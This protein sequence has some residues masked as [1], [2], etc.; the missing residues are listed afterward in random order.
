M[1]SQTFAENTRLHIFSFLDI[2]NRSINDF[3]FWMVLNSI[4]L[5]DEIWIHINVMVLKWLRSFSICVAILNCLRPWLRRTVDIFSCKW[6]KV[7]TV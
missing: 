3:D 2:I 6:T 1:Y 4:F 7:F 5:F